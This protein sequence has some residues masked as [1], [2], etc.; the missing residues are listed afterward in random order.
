MTVALIL[1]GG[2]GKRLAP[3]THELPK[4]LLPAGSRRIIEYQLDWLKYYG[5]NEV[6]LLVGYMKE[7]IIDALG[8]GARYG[9]HISYIVEDD[10]LGTGGA[11]RNAAHIMNRMEP[12]IVVNGDIVTNIDVRRLMD[13]LGPALASIALVPLRS[14]YGVVELQGNTIV[15][16]REKPT[17]RDYWINAGAYAMRREVLEHLPE[18]GDVER[19][20][21]PLLA[22]KRLLAGVKFETPPYYWRSV[23]S[24]KDLEEIPRE[25]EQ[26]GGLFAGL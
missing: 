19:T 20:T 17:L 1:A 22:S 10:L 6:F 16:F 4:V 14:P 5:I 21:F 7:K 12:V 3:L 18:H 8:S 26:I 2:L 11:L 15:S 9:V 23:D 13:P 25:L 24:P